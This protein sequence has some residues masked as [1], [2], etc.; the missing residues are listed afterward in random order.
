[1]VR[2]GTPENGKS[3]KPLHELPGP[4]RSPDFI[5]RLNGLSYRYDYTYRLVKYLQEHSDIDPD[6]L[7]RITECY[8]WARGGVFDDTSIG[9][10]IFRSNACK[11]HRLC[12]NCAHIRAKKSAMQ[13]AEAVF[14]LV[15]YYPNVRPVFTTITV[16]NGP[17]IGE[18]FRHVMN[19]FKRLQMKRKNARKGLTKSLRKYVIGGLF[20]CEIKFTD[21]GLWHPH[22]HG[23][24][25]LPRWVN[26]REYDSE[27]EKDWLEITKDSFVTRVT[28]I[29]MA[30][31]E[32]LIRS[33]MEICKY[34]MKQASMTPALQY[35]AYRATHNKQLV[36]RFGV[37]RGFTMDEKYD[38][39]LPKMDLS[40]SPFTE[41]LMMRQSDTTGTKFKVSMGA[42][43][44]GL[45]ENILRCMNDEIT[46]DEKS[47]SGL[48]SAPSCDPDSHLQSEAV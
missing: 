6:V 11:Q 26:L 19:G 38:R 35:E 40:A 10:K 37:L 31:P 44:S 48:R 25:I 24:E 36:R 14:A 43:W 46:E 30:T 45:T 23:L 34:S 18:R 13:L 32:E 1:M 20:S 42:K 12:A 15:L 17:D 47:S 8:N 4:V 27:L 9:V 33:C 29:R 5:D 39:Y 2:H 3:G 22:L 41:F 28:E 7:R 16:K 21:K